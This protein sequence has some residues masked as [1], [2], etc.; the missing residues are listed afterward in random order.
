MARNKRLLVVTQYCWPENMRINDLITDFVA[1]GYAVTVLTG[2]PNYPEGERYRDF[3]RN[4][5]SFSEYHGAEIIRVPMISRGQNVITLALNYLSFFISASLWGPLLLRGRRF[6]SI[7]VYAVSPIMAAIPALIIGRIKTVP[8][9][10]WILDLWPDTLR[11]I[12]IVHNEQ[13]LR[14]IGK[15]VSWIYNR[16]DY[17]LLQSRAFRNSVS[18]HCTRHLDDKRITYFP[19]WAEDDFS[20]ADDRPS[21]ILSREEDLFTIVF[22]GNLGDAQN[23]P[24]I[25]SA[26]EV[27][28]DLPIRWVLVGDGR[29][30]DWLLQEVQSRGLSNVS[31]PGRYPLTEMPAL[32]KVADALLVSLRADDVFAKTI[33]GKVQ[34]YLAAGR[35]IL[36]MIDGE[37]QRVIRESGGGMACDAGDHKALA[38]LARSLLSM[39]E[40]ARNAMGA[41][42]REYYFRHF[43]KEVLFDQLNTLFETGSCRRNK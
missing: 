32:F 39:P 7:F 18:S 27:L 4:P 43:S 26:V 21:A 40:S 38:R 13:L 11:A 3:K 6:D 33:P 17:L 25:L 28:S 15:I 10:I 30:A 16:A 22:A 36:A 20:T 19:S 41:A 12:G 2:K 1:R 34:A 14:A 24:A 5:S 37:A 23:F 8:V 42:G 9:F 29:S 31:L 35:P